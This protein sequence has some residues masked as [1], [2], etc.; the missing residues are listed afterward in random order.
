MTALTLEDRVEIAD[1][2]LRY[3]FAFDD[4]QDA[5][6]ADLFTEDG[7]FAVD[8]LAPVVG[9]EA[10]ASMV[11][12]SAAR[13]PGGR[14]LLSGVLVQ[15]SPVGAAGTAYVQVVRVEASAL[16]LVA[17][18]RYADEIVPT[19][20]GWKFQTRRFTPFSGPQLGGAI[21]AVPVSA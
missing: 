15:A 1:L 9:R 4:V 11:R 18:G 10:L 17:L 7:S 12:A 13:A 19:A 14:H 5:D 6:C 16:R 3:S 20:Y 2:Y 21:L 8:G